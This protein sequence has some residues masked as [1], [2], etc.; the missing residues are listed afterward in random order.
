[1]LRPLALCTTE[2]IA[3]EVQTLE[4]P[5]GDDV[6]R[7]GDPGE[8]FYVIEAGELEAVVDG[9]PVRT[10]RSG[11]SFGEIA[12]IRDIPRTATVRAVTPAV[13]TVIERDHFLAAVMGRR[14]AAAA[15]EAVVRG[16]LGG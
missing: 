16:H 13:L 2:E 10:L 4:V 12:L 14:D 3:S 9:Q 5:A 1:M 7:Q 11:D 15:A 8:S 6:V